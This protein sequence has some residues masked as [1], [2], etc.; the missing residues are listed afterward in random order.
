MA[1]RYKKYLESPN[2]SCIFYLEAA[3]R[4]SADEE[5]DVL[6]VGRVGEHVDGLDS[7][8]TVVSVEIV[9]VTGLC[10]G[11]AGDIDDALGSCPEDGL[12][13]IGVHA[14]TWWVSDDHIGTTVLSDEV[15]GEDVLHVSGIEEG[16]GDTVDL[17]VHLRVLDGLG[18]VFDADDLTGFLCYEIGDSASAGVEIIY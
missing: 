14:G 1:Q 13:H 9:E 6:D 8:Y 16:V 12:H 3:V 18:H 10:G 4:L 7:G 17:G 5:D 11:V 15:I 2:I